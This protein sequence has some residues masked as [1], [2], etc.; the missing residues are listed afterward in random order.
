MI[1]LHIPCPIRHWVSA[2]LDFSPSKN[3]CYHFNHSSTVDVKK[4]VKNVN[5]STEIKE[6]YIIAVYCL[7]ARM[8]YYMYN[9][10]T[11]K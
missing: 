7:F 9:F 4:D 10:T 1:T 3:K 5:I 2:V 6:K 11:N 8:S